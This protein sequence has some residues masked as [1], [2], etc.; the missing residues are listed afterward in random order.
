MS[1][2]SIDYNTYKHRGFYNSISH[3]TQL[4]SNELSSNSVA[5]L[6]MHTLLQAIRD[7]YARPTVHARN[8]F[9]TSI[10]FYDIWALHE[11]A[12]PYLAG[13]YKPNTYEFSSILLNNDD[14]KRVSISYAAHTLLTHRFRNSPRTETQTLLNNL[15]DNLDYYEGYD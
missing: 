7:D 6:W 12:D 10:A 9:H 14:S 2:K 1:L 11:N 4:K 15:L 3:K 5:R 13:I 8:L